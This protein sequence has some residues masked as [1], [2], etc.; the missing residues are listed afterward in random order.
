VL[1]L[2]IMPGQVAALVMGS[3]LYHIMVKIKPLSGQRWKQIKT[4]CA[5]QVSP[6]PG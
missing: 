3:D 2:Q 4:Q 5:G 1:D 6:A